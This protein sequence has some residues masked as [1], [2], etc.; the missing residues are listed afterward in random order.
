MM[1]PQGRL[2]AIQ[3]GTEVSEQ[4]LEQ[5]L[6]LRQLMILDLQSKEAYQAE[7]VQKEQAGAAGEQTFFGYQPWHSDGYTPSLP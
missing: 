3:I 1:T 4:Q 2:D 6:M 7:Q 5:L